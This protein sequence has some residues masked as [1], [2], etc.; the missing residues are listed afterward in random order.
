EMDVKRRKPNWT[1]RELL[2]LAEAVA[3]RS[4]LLKSKISPSITVDRKQKM[5]SEI[6]I[7]L[8]SITLVN[9]TIDEIKKKWVDM[10]S[11]TKKTESE[12]R[13]SIKMT[14]GGPALDVYYKAWENVV[15]QS[16]SE[17]AIEGISCGV[18]TAESESSSPSQSAITPCVVSD[19]PSI[20]GSEETS[21]Q[22]Q[23]L[24]FQKEKLAKVSDYRKRK[25]DIM[26]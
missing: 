23:Y 18:D 12:R 11:L 8:N 24:I 14:G 25:L 19:E 7:Q 20:K 6:A 15:L 1:E 21:P 2:A 3:P 9:R 16:L 17:V 22:E 5:W 4:R 10:Q 26:E 13:R